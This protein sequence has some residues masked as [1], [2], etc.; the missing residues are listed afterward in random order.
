[1]DGKQTT[2]GL[3]NLWQIRTFVFVNYTAY[4]SK[5]VPRIELFDNN[6]HN[7]FINGNKLQGTDEN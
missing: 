6:Y 7:L 3:D 4:E 2:E 1:M 5:T